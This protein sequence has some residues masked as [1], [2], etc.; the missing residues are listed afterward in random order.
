METNVEGVFLCCW[1]SYLDEIRPRSIVV[2]VLT[3]IKGC[4]GKHV[5]R[6]REGEKVP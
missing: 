3:V 5:R 6:E 1:Q 2:I 4:Y